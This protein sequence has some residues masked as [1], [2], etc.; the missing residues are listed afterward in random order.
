MNIIKTVSTRLYFKFIMLLMMVISSVEVVSAQQN[1]ELQDHTVGSNSTI[2]GNILISTTF[3]LSHSES[4][5]ETR[6]I[7][8]LDDSYRLDWNITLRSGYF[9]KDNFALGAFFKYSNK[10]DQLNYTND[11][12]EVFDETLGR[13]Y[14]FAP[15]MR[16]YL[17]LGK[18]TF[19]LFNET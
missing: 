14:S 9:I 4:K 5:N 11:T 18:G 13:S 2:K 8:N 12:G 3:S 17:P 10:L 6:L 19:S 1:E 7:Q 15:F 16:N